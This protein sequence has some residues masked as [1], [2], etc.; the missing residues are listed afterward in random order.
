M[1]VERPVSNK[2]LAEID[3]L[4][5][6]LNQSWK[7][8]DEELAEEQRR[9]EQ[10]GMNWFE[11]LEVI[12]RRQMD[13]LRG[14]TAPFDFGQL[15]RLLDELCSLYLSAD[16]EQRVFIRDL[17]EDK[18]R[19]RKYLHSYIGGRAAPRLESTGDRKWLDLGL[20]AA[21]IVDQRVDW[22]DLLIALGALW[23]SA[24]EA[25]IAP[26]RRFS[27]VARISTDEPAYGGSSTS[28]LLRRFRDSGHLRSIKEKRAES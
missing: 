26:A 1:S 20:A 6:R 14:G 19:L 5:A 16:Q 28:D 13:A 8:W 24:E 3:V 11:A 10:A 21:S 17:F 2:R 15:N 18:T 7:T 25:G 9:V 22:R 27:S 23:L 12:H 4:L